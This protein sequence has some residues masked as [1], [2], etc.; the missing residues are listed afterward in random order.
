MPAHIRK[1]D[2]VV[3]NSG[4]HKGKIGKVKEVWPK[5]Q[6]VVVEGLNLRTKHLKPTRTAPQ[7]GIITREEP[8]HWSKVNPVVDGKAVRVGFKTKADGTKVRVARHAKKEL[9]ELGTIRG[10]KD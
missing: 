6:K 8:L 2:T 7:G 1:G 10:R 3:V 9:G 5:D 4:Q